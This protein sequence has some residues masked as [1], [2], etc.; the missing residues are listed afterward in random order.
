MLPLLLLHGVH[1]VA[2][3]INAF[4]RLALLALG[5]VQLLVTVVATNKT[6]VVLLP[7]VP[8]RFYS[9]GVGTLA[10]VVLAKIIAL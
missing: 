2:L 9:S 1:A 6:L 3:P 10:S 7:T 8:L 4:S 5:A